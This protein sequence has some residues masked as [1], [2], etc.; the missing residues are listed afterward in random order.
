MIFEISSEIDRVEALFF[1]E[2]EQFHTLPYIEA[3]IKAQTS[4]KPN[5]AHN[6]NE[7]QRA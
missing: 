1:Y 6:K 4:L 3:E 7:S 5:K 2:M